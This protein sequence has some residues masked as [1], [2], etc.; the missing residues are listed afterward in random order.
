MCGLHSIILMHSLV[1]INTTHTHT[2]TQH[3]L[4]VAIR[5]TFISSTEYCFFPLNLASNWWYTLLM[6]PL[7]FDSISLSDGGEATG[8]GAACASISRL[9]DAFPA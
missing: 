8:G 7:T 5:I 2:H 3:T 1:M 4:I 9:T 6:I